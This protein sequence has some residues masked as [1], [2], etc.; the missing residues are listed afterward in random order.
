MG[1][2]WCGESTQQKTECMS[3]IAFE[4]I[5]LNMKK[6]ISAFIQTES[7]KES[8]LWNEQG[9]SEMQKRHQSKKHP[10]SAYHKK[11]I[12]IFWI[13]EEENTAVSWSKYSEVILACLWGLGALVVGC[14]F[15]GLV[16]FG[17]G[18]GG[19]VGELLL[20]F[21]W[22]QTKQLWELIY[23]FSISFWFIGHILGEKIFC[24]WETWI[25]KAH[26]G[27][28]RLKTCPNTYHSH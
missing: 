14:F 17:F 19:A 21:A 8:S 18:G 13:T 16:W 6:G 27:N 15:L 20:V 3:Y 28:E 25:V 12:H 1:S 24:F 10:D 2:G 23:E 5:L 9:S 7:T 4:K 26:K 22:K 11:K